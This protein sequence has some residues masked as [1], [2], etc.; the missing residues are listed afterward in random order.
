MELSEDIGKINEFADKKEY[1]INI[2][3]NEDNS[4]TYEVIGCTL[5]EFVNNEILL[6]EVSN[7]FNEVVSSTKVTIND[8][9]PI[10]LPNGEYKLCIRDKY[11]KQ[12]SNTIS[13]TKKDG[14]ICEI[15]VENSK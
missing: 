13:Y 2:K 15:E 5:E 11:H 6:R 8:R 4:L 7:E 14:V 12:V 1:R 10:N 9:L 3:V